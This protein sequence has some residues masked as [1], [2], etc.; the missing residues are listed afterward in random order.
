MLLSIITP[1]YNVAP[2]L[3][4]TIESILHQT[5]RDFELILVDDGSTDGSERIS[6]HYASLDSRIRVIHQDNQG[7][8]I[9][10]NK[11]IEMSNGDI[12][13]FVDGDDII[14]QDMYQNMIA[15]MLQSEAEI[16]QCGHDRY[17]NCIIS[18]PNG[19]NL[20]YKCISGKEFVMQMFD[21]HGAE[22][23]N[24]VALWSKIYKRN[25][26]ETIH[27]PE[28]QTYE[29]EHETYKAC[30]SA[31]KIA[32]TDAVYYHYIK[33][34]NSI[35]T[36]I[37]PIKLLDKQKALLDRCMW[38]PLRMPELHHQC[39]THFIEYSKHI[40]CELWRSRCMDE[41][42]Q[43]MHIFFNTKDKYEIYLNRYDQF[44]INLLRHNIGR[45]WIMENNFAPIQYYIRK[46][47]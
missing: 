21:K 18:S 44:Y 35:I 17:S 4:A 40:L 3:S 7:V 47:K 36:G 22:Y 38:L 39:F 41:F 31:C 2:F 46:L 25:I 16:V 5:F 42:N 33:R 32:M 15:I 28:G 1:V 14:S 10:R 20:S 6:H 24:Q 34:E 19:Q 27:F 43:A 8:S 9:A 37:S 45:S 23:T 29:D 13:G 11:G 12:I 26:I 30:F